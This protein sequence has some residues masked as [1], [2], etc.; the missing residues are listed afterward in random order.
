MVPVVTQIASENRNT[1]AVARLDMDDSP[2][3]VRKYVVRGRPAYIVF[4]NGEIV[5]R[6]AGMKTKGQLLQIILNA[7]NK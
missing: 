4:Q 2:E 5:G 6:T 3:I 7:I 1:F